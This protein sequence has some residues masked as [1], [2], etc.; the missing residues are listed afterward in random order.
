MSGGPRVRLV[1]LGAALTGATRENATT[2][3]ELGV[4][5]DWIEARTGI[6]RR[7]VLAPG[8]TL[9]DLACAAA[10]EA[11]GPTPPDLVIAATITAPEATPALAS[12]VQQRLG[13]A[14]P[15]FDVSAAC[16]G[17]VY[18]L[19][20]ARAH[21]LAGDA[22]RVLVVG[23]D[24]LSGRV[25]AAD[26]DTAI[27]FGDAAGAAVLAL[28]EGPGP[29]VEAVVLGGDARHADIL[30]L[31]AHVYM[32]GRQVYRLAARYLEDAVRQVCA[33]AGWAPESVALL[34][35]HQA[36]R[37]LLEA[38]ARRLELPFERVV[39]DIEDVGNTSAASVPVALAHA[40]AAGRLAGGQRV[41]LVGL[42]AGLVHA[43]LALT[44]GGTD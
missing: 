35:P 34:V 13:L 10:A 38:V 19:A 9:L 6:Q 24:A 44:W 5:P 14:G 29:V 37:R 15:A 16:A 32:E 8:E 21:L 28:G 41:V 11:L 23:A 25:D 36:N 33:R 1:G 17:F 30:G 40:R 3:A 27:L 22:T 12:R 20:T 31:G 18:G 4:T 43:A 2:A 39:C 7:R 26:R 42:G